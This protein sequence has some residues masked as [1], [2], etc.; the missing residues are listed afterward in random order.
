MS[1]Q[2]TYVELVIPGRPRDIGGFEVR[3]VLPAA[4]HRMVGPFIFLDEMGPKELA[5]GSGIDVRPHPHIG[6]ATVT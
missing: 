5:P 2:Q 4:G 3:R 1:L 6:L